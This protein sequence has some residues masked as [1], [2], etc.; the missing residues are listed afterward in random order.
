[1]FW[2][3]PQLLSR[4][5]KVATPVLVVTELAGVKVPRPAMTQ[6]EV[7]DTFTGVPIADDDSATVNVV[8][9]LGGSAGS[10]R[11]DVNDVIVTFVAA[12]WKPPVAV[13]VAL[14]TLAVAV[15]VSAPV[16]VALAGD[17]VTIA[18]PLS[19]VKAE[20]GSNFPRLPAVVNVTTVPGIGA[21]VAVRSE[22]VTVAG[23]FAVTVDEDNAKV[24]V[25]VVTGVFVPPPPVPP[26]PTTGV[27]ASPPPP[28]PPQAASTATIVAV[29]IRRA[30]PRVI[31]LPAPA[32]CSIRFMS[33]Y[34]CVRSIVLAAASSLI[35][36]RA[37]GPFRLLWRHFSRERPLV[38]DGR[39]C[40]AAPRR[41]H[42]QRVAVT[43]S[44]TTFGVMKIS[45]SVFAELR[46]LFLNR[47]PSSGIS[48]RYGTLFSVSR[49]SCV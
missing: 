4:K 29:S 18:S 37:A 48:P 14:L 1:M 42:N 5:R 20:A 23:A 40:E 27:P 47:L 28:P 43:R 31:P 17:S 34:S 49:S 15:I 36:A 22:A 6:A 9:P 25:G 19:L 13:T 2:K 24:I 46:D 32:T 12:S 11:S 45:S 7:S 26:P 21:P 30:A 3:L 35:C 33:C 41:R 44:L 38:H 8:S 16:L 10:V 39:C